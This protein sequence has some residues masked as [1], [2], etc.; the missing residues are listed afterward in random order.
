ML[1]Q[2]VGGYEENVVG[3]MYTSGLEMYTGIGGPK[4]DRAPSAPSTFG[5]EVG[6]DSFSSSL[7][8]F[9]PINPVVDPVLYGGLEVDFIKSTL[10]TT[11]I[12]DRIGPIVDTYIHHDDGVGR[13]ETKTIRDLL[14]KGKIKW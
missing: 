10:K 1:E 11:I 5:R 4:F 13:L 7:P 14:G 6:G 2:V 12:K 9:K 3:E 8:S